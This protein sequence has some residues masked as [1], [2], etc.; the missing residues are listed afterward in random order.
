MILTLAKGREFLGLTLFLLQMIPLATL[1]IWHE[2]NQMVKDGFADTTIAIGT[3]LTSFIIVTAVST[4]VMIEG[5][6]ML[7]E[8]FARRL[9]KMRI[10]QGRAI[11]YKRWRD[12]YET[13]KA[14]A[15][16]GKPLPEPLK[17]EP[18]AED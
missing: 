2:T 12:W 10:Q 3:S 8:S 7:Y 14:E 1:V 13:V 5:S 17:P 9:R 16:Q 6:A 11:E 4:V 18:V 15:N